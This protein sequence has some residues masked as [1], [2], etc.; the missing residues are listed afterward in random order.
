MNKFLSSF[1]I[2]ACC[3]HAALALSDHT[4]QIYMYTKPSYDSLSMQRSSWDAMTTH[5]QKQGFAFQAMTFAQTSIH[6]QDS[7]T[8]YFNFAN[9][10]ILNVTTGTTGSPN[11]YNR[12]SFSR[13]VLGQWLGFS[14]VDGQSITAGTIQ[15]SPQ[16]SAYGCI[17][18][19]NQDLNQFFELSFLDTLS[20]GVAIPLTNINNKLNFSGSPEVKKALTGAYAQNITPGQTWHYA[21]LNTQEQE[22]TGVENITIKLQSTYANQHDVLLATTSSIMIPLHDAIANKYLFEPMQS[23]NGHIAVASHILIQF[24]LYAHENSPA[25]LNFYFAAENKWFVKNTQKRTFQI[26]NRPYSHYMPILDRHTQL[27]LPGVNVFTKDCIVDPYNHFY[28]STG[29]RF[30]YY[31]S[32]GEV[33]Y[34]IWGRPTEGVTIKNTNA[35]EENRYAI[36]SIT[37]AD[38]G[39]TQAVVDTTDGN[40]SGDI[41]SSSASTINYVAPADSTSALENVYI[42][43]T[44]LQ[45]LAACARSAIVHRGYASWSL[46]RKG[47]KRD[48][49]LN[50]GLFLE[51]SQNNA[52]LSCWGGWLK[53]GFTF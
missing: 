29:L 10:E 3:T 35:W 31:D 39:S 37:I 2:I 7:H 23:Y 13:D 53:T 32:I 26:K 38:D 46:G 50:L 47:N 11:Y 36:P 40:G 20:I 34:E 14:N 21:L 42:R 24:P 12:E 30:S 48:M 1:F 16:Q 18:E 8:A 22:V 5:K 33:G 45:M 44:D 6:K 4:N 41:L 49:F 43:T 9:K 25:R 17:L 52:V 27:L 15:F 51:H 19:M 28:F